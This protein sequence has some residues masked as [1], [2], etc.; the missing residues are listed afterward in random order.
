M[1]VKVAKLP[2]DMDPADMIRLRGATEWKKVVESAQHIVLVYLAV[3]KEHQ[4]NEHT[5]MRAVRDKILPYLAVM[6]SAVER[7][8]FVREIHKATGISESALTDDLALLM[9]KEDQTFKARPVETPQSRAV[10][11]LQ[12]RTTRIADR[13]FGIVFWQESMDS[14]QID[15][16]TV[17]QRLEDI[18]ETANFK[19]L[20]EIAP[21]KKNER[22]FE[23]ELLYTDPKKLH[24]DVE[25]L[26]SNLEEEVLGLR[27]LELMTIMNDAE[28][29]GDTITLQAALSESQR[30]THRLNTIKSNRFLQAY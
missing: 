18:L 11:I 6:P 3:L 12:S 26:M 4:M 28:K 19:Q 27:L 24:S 16:P 8:H 23:V 25:E 2:K 10:P 9:I 14:P 7:D 13:I 5:R 21:D 29:G 17:R 22:I 20:Y 1:N 15:L 30:I